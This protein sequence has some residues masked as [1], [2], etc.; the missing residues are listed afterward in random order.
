MKMDAKMICQ[1]MM[2]NV[3][4]LLAPAVLLSKQ[5][6]STSLM[7]AVPPTKQNTA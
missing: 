5:R 4:R 7:I 3:G 1:L 6:P 2:T